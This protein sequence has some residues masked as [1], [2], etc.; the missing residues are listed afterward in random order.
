MEA[1]PQVINY[2]Y[3]S[4]TPSLLQSVTLNTWLGCLLSFDASVSDALRERP[5]GAEA[6]FSRICGLVAGGALPLAH[7]PALFSAKVDGVLVSYRWLGAL[8]PDCESLVKSRDNRWAL[9]LLGSEH[10]VTPH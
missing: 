5:G 1:K 4:S 7:A 9:S 8:A 10:G 2:W 6:A 3:T